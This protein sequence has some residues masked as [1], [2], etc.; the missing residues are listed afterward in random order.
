MKKG[1]KDKKG[2]KSVSTS[3][4]SFDSFLYV[5]KHF[6]VEA[7]TLCHNV[8]CVN[9]FLQFFEELS[10][11]GIPEKVHEVAVKETQGKQ[12]IVILKVGL[13]NITFSASCSL[14]L[15]KNYTLLYRKI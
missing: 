11:D 5:S 14:L 1:K 8:S 3:H 15:I 12:V 13:F 6:I 2:K 9:V 4:D 7:L 10:T